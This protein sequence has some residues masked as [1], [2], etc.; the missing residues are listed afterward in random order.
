MVAI[1]TES[2][3]FGCTSNDP[4]QRCPQVKPARAAPANDD[5]SPRPILVLEEFL[6]YRLN[7]LAAVV[8]N[9]L[10][11]LYERRF[12]LTIPGWRVI[13]TLG[14]FDTRTA[15]DIAAHGV[16]HKS[17]VSRAV[18]ALVERGLVRRSPNPVDLR[19]DLLA[20]T[21]E[22]RAIYEAI[23]P[24]ALA[25]EAELAGALSPEEREVLAGLLDRL[26]ERGRSIAKALQRDEPGEG[27]A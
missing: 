25:V 20:L 7:V 10:A 13:A 16:M 2:G 3:I 23:A 17:T 6:P 21:P 9:A 14:Q 8:S 5:E 12:G 27:G 15:R 4:C 11:G 26:D 22:G 24:Q 19:E 1:A 18:A